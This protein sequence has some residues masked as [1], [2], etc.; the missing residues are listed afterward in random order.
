MHSALATREAPRLLLPAGRYLHRAPTPPRSRSV[1]GHLVPL[2]DHYRLRLDEGGVIRLWPEQAH[3]ELTPLPSAV[4]ETIASAHGAGGLR[5]SVFCKPTWT[6]YHGAYLEG[7]GGLISNELRA[8]QLL[9]HAE[10]VNGSVGIAYADPGGESRRFVARAPDVWLL[11]L[12][13]RPLRLPPY[14]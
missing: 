11:G 9:R 2:E 14:T 13:G 10:R 6:L 8:H 12:Y 7:S 1:A 4:V 5:L 3:Q